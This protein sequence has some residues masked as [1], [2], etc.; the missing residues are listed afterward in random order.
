MNISEQ[1]RKFLRESKWSQSRLAAEIGVNVVSLNRYLLRQKKKGT[2]E[3]LAEFLMERGLA[4][5]PAMPP[6]GEAS[7]D[8][9]ELGGP[10][11]EMD[12]GPDSEVDRGPGREGY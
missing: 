10:D 11:R 3:R 9:P 5:A 1:T 2:G 6:T 8:A 4:A 12:S 7:G